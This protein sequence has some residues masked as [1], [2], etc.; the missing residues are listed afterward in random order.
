MSTEPT[1]KGSNAQI[2]EEPL[3]SS[4]WIRIL[5]LEKARWVKA[6]SGKGRKLATWARETLNRQARRDGVDW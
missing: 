4:L 5:P 3:T 2:H 6:A 1:T